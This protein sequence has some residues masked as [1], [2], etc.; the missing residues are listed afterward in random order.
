MVVFPDR[1]GCQCDSLCTIAISLT[2]I[3]KI[4][5]QS[6]AGMVVFPD[7]GGCQCD[8]FGLHGATDKKENY[9]SFEEFGVNVNKIR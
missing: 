1:G 8:S 7:R 4:D 6:R 5:T 3:C 2:I 9:R